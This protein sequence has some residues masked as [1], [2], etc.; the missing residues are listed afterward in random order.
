MYSGH[1]AARYV[2]L[3]CKCR[4]ASTPDTQQW[5]L[6]PP[7]DIV[8]GTWRLVVESVIG[9]RLGSGA[10]IAT[11]PSNPGRPR[12]ICVYTSDW[13]DVSDV[14][15][16]LDELVELGLCPREGNGIYYKNDA[17]TYL[18]I[19]SGNAYGLKA[20]LYSSRDMLKEGAGARR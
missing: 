18:G 11:G 4:T 10:K 14:R 1:V 7:D 5:M 16:V 6:F 19:D 20:S 15:R 9:N 12:L 17:F 2:H 13:S 8:D 3:Q